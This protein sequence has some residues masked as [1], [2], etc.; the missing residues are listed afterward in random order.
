VALDDNV[1]RYRQ[2]EHEQRVGELEKWVR[3]T[4][5]ELARISLTLGQLAETS[6]ENRRTLKGM[7]VSLAVGV[8][9]LI[10]TTLIAKL[11]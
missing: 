4:E 8:A 3:T 10:A 6:L 11:S 2:E 7:V 9:L 5:A 1:L